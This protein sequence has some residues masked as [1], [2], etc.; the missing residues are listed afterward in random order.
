MRDGTCQ[1]GLELSATRPER[2]FL[3]LLLLLSLLPQGGTHVRQYMQMRLY[4]DAFQKER[5]PSQLQLP[6]SGCAPVLFGFRVF[7]E[8][9][10]GRVEVRGKSASTC[11]RPQGVSDA[12]VDSGR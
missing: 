8:R 9:S 4:Y 3:L 5:N 11:F 2:S 10:L 12:S 7:V 1:I 6:N